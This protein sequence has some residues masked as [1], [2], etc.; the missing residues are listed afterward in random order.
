MLRFTAIPEKMVNVMAFFAEQ[1]PGSTKMKIFKLMYYADKEHL[2]RYGRPIT[3]DRYVRMKWGPTPSTSYDM[4]KGSAP[5]RQMTLF[6]S[7]LAVHGNTMKG[8]HSPDM[9][10]FSRSDET[11]LREIV[12]RYGKMT[13]AQL[14]NLSHREATWT[15]TQENRLIDFELMF[16]NRP[17]ATLTLDLL[18]EESSAKPPAAN[19]K[20]A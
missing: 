15:K 13:A 6:Q 12:G 20:R 2:L 3:G 10:V 7:K 5:L 1:C 18:T 19:A 9:T 8:L 14:S 11:I 17:D 16:A 4:T